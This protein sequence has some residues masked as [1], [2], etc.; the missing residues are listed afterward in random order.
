LTRAELVDAVAPLHEISPAQIATVVA[1]PPEEWGIT[2]EERVEVCKYLR[3]RQLQL[4]ALYGPMKSVSHLRAR[5][6]E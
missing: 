5:A 3:L 1:M 4:L 6:A 2:V